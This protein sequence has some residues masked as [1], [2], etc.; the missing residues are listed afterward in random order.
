MKRLLIASAL[1]LAATGVA[2][3]DD[4]WK[5]AREAQKAHYEAKR[6][7]EKERNE[8]R[9][10]AAK[11]RREAE[12][13]YWK[14]RREAAREYEKDR[15]EAQREY[16]KDRREHFR[17]LAKGRREW[18]RGQHIP[19]AY[20]D[21]RYYVD[22]YRAYRLAPPPRGYVWVRPDPRDNEVYLVQVATGVIA[23]IL[24]Y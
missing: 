17:E 16:E 5:E 13:E 11:D 18:A 24:G 1:M 14:D 2:R 10:E 23:R 9:R 6:E 21:D 15:R 3:A 7:Y 22:D 12:R 19:R 4:P 20:L 8:A